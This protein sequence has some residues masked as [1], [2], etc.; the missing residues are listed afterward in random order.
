[1]AP[2]TTGFDALIQFTQ[3]TRPLLAALP[4]I[5]A[6]ILVLPL[7]PTSLVPA[8]LKAAFAISMCLI[9]YPMLKSTFSTNDW[10][11]AQWAGYVVKEA[12]VGAM[13]GYTMGVVIW[14]MGSIGELIDI[15][16]GFNNAKIFDPFSAT[17]AGP[18]SAFMNQLGVLI[19][20]SLGGLQ[21]FLQLL[22]ESLI[23]WPPQS[24]YPELGAAMRDFAIGTSG[25]VLE[26]ATRLAAPVIGAL[27]IAELGI[28]L[29]NR[30]APQLNSFYFSMPIKALTALLMLSLLMSHLVD[31]VQDHFVKMQNILPELNR[32]L[33]GP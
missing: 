2:D 6:A 8:R 17:P 19:F 31:V 30:V 13:V 28:G 25:T 1:M 4:R 33:K 18:M 26:L 5:G 27:L 12:L 20:V 3:L 10:D 32:S 7:L 21:V 23:L 29:I 16:A 22:Y 9:T 15:Q 11:F 24:F 14:A